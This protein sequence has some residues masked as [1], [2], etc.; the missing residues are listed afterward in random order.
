EESPDEPPAASQEEVILSS[1][2]D[3]LQ[4]RLKE[5]EEMRAEAERKAADVADRFRQMQNQLKA[6]TEE[7]RARIQRNLDQKLENAR[8]DIVTSL[9]DTLDNLKRAVAA[10]EKSERRDG[11]F[12]SLL[13]GIRATVSM[14][15]AKM[16]SLGLTA[17]VSLGED[18]NPEIHE[19]VEIVDVPEEQ[20]HKVIEE[21]QAG[22][23]F[24]DRLLRPARVRVGRAQ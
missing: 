18:F 20:D 11:D 8:S 15:E 21:F 6:E 12:D 5:A 19:A 4:A 9:L 23:K 13:E 10:A 24:G 16:Q 22:Y 7:Q 14:F 1:E 17:I 3:Q 2:I